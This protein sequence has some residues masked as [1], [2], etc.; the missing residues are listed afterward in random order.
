[1]QRTRHPWA[2]A[3]APRAVLAALAAAGGEGR[4]VGGCVRDSLLGRPITDIDIATPLLPEAVMAA[5]REAGIAAVPTGLQHGTVTAVVRGQPRG[6]DRLEITTLRQDVETDGRHALVVFT[7]DWCLDA[8]RRDLT[9]NALFLDAK[10]EIYD[11]V[12]G[13]ADLEARRVRFVGDPRRRIEEDYLRILRFLRFHAHYAEGPPDPMA[14]EAASSLAP[15][16]ERISGERKRNEMLRLLEAPDPLPVV[17]IMRERGILAH[18]LPEADGGPRLARLLA[19]APESDALLRLAS[20]LPPTAEA[21]S[22]SA[23]RLRLSRR[24]AKRLDAMLEAAREGAALARPRARRALLYRQGPQALLERG[25]SAAAAGLLDPAV[26]QELREEAAS[27]QARALPVD[28][29]DLQALGLEGPALGQALRALE[30]L[31][32]DQAFRPDRAA[33]LEEAKKR[34]TE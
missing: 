5:L 30:A 1:M 12:G 16:L 28:G 11:F 33:L 18:V 6:H 4:F 3:P 21:G 2:E 31:W 10:G 32:L 15:G 8:R 22:A 25:I 27:W 20:L 23:G 19:L 7:Q 9:M 13:E 34:L 29:R 17:A 26:L 14:L 24:Q